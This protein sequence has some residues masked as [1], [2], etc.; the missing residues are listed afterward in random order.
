MPCATQLS[1]TLNSSEV[2]SLNDRFFGEMA[3]FGTSVGGCPERW[4]DEGLLPELALTRLGY[5]GADFMEGLECL[6]KTCF[7]PLGN[8]IVFSV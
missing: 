6:T 4:P 2:E 3:I 1:G 5:A 7:S 8:R